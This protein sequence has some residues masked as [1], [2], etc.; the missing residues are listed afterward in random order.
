MSKFKLIHETIN[1]DKIIHIFNTEVLE[2]VL[3]NM[4]FFIRGCSFVVDEYASLD[5]I[6][7]ETGNELIDYGSPD[8]KLPNKP[9]KKRKK[10]L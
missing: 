2:T 8:T 1:G 3:L 5:F 7:E 4:G 9:R 10:G 6:R